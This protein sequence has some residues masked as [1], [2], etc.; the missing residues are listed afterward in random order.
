M[1]LQAAASASASLPSHAVEVAPEVSSHAIDGAGDLASHAVQDAHESIPSHALEDEGLPSYALQHDVSSPQSSVGS[2]RGRPDMHINLDN[3]IAPESTALSPRQSSPL[4]SLAHP[5]LSSSPAHPASGFNTARTPL[6]NHAVA[7]ST[8]SDS[9][10]Y[11]G[12]T[13]LSSH[14]VADSIDSDSQ[15]NTGRTPLSS[16][17]VNPSSSS[18]SGTDEGFTP[19]SVQQQPTES[20][21]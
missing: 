10:L 4:R 18:G 20:F 3:A 16:H 2:W 12:Q 7:D 9:Q 21:Y 13:P 11:T 17:A 5:A 6:S 15:L 14:A 19:S 8:D 1:Q